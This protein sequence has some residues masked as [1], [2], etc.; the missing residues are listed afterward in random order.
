[1][2]GGILN[3][4]KIS[5][6]AIGIAMISMM[7][8]TTLST[9][10]GTDSVS[11]VYAAESKELRNAKAKIS[12]LTSSLKTNYLGLKNQG[13]W[14]IYIKQSRD[15]IKKIPNSEKVQKN[16]LTLEVNKDESLVNALGRVNQVEKSITPKDKGGYGNS[17]TIKNAETWNEYLRLAKTDLE[18]VDKNIFKKQYDELIARLNNVSLIV[19]GIEDKF[20]VEYEKIV[21][22]YEEAKKSG[23]LDKL[24]EVLKEAEKLGTCDRSNKLENDIKTII[25]NKLKKPDLVKFQ[26]EDWSS[27]IVVNK[28]LN[29]TFSDDTLTQDDYLYLNYSFLND[30]NIPIEKTIYSQIY[31]DNK[32]FKLEAFPNGLESQYYIE[33][34]NIYIGNLSPG[35]HNIKVVLDSK[36][37]VDEINEDNNV[38]ETTVYIR[39]SNMDIP[40]INPPITNPSTDNTLIEL[41]RQNYLKELENLKIKIENVKSEKNIQVLKKQEDGSYKFEWV[42][43]QEAIDRAQSEYD[44]K[45]A[46]YIAW[47]NSIK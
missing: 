38:M 1:M 10:L 11:I 35:T 42:A 32:E 3:M 20:Q 4:I 40:S 12:H 29:S 39:S 31:I 26:I 19:K 22:L 14:Q 46:Q 7:T 44:R 8:I 15:L 34:K 17:L 16:N 5:K 47:E 13:M 36:N 45:Y 9:V 37:I 6:K 23:N 21:K 41:T 2:I 18:K 24:K 43:D 25:N 28:T 33:Y 27:H 30:S